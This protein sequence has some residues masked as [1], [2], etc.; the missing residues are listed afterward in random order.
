MFILSPTCSHYSFLQEL[1]AIKSGCKIGEALQYRLNG[2][3]FWFTNVLT[4]EF[5]VSSKE[6]MSFQETTIYLNDIEKWRNI[7]LRWNILPA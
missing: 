7:K 1:L 6:E 5:L 3:Q 4:V 2:Q